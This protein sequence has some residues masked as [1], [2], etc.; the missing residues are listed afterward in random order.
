[1]AVKIPT[2]EDRLVPQGAGPSPN[3]RPAEISD[4]IGRGLQNL[5]NAGM[6]FAATNYHLEQKRQTETAINNMG[7]DL[8][9]AS[10]EWPDRVAKLSKS[11]VNGGMVPQEDGTFKPLTQQ[12]KEEWSTYRQGFLDKI[13]NEKVRMYASSQLD[14]VW[15][16]TYRHSLST[17]ATLNVNNKLDKI[18]QTVTTYASGAATDLGIAE[19]NLKATKELI[20]NSGLDEH[21]RNQTALAAQKSIVEAAVTGALKRDP[22][23][24]RAAL[25]QRFGVTEDQ[26]AAGAN[27]AAT[28]TVNTVW[29]ALINQESGGKQTRPD[30]T[31][32]TSPKGALGIAQIMPGTGPEAAKLAGLPW[33]LNRL[34]TDPDYNEKLGKAYLNK[35]LQTFN[36]DMTKALAAYNM[37]PGEAS[38]GNGVSGLVAKYG[39]QWLEHAPKETQNYVATITQRVG[40][41]NMGTVAVNPKVEIPANL[42]MMVAMLDTDRAPAFLGEA[43]TEIN[44]QQATY[45][46]QVASTENDHVA[47]YMNGQP[48]QKPLSEADYTKAYGPVEGPQR[49][50]Q[51]QQIGVM[52]V[53]MNALKLQT[54]EQMQATVQKYQP[55][56]AKPGYDLANKRYAAVVEAANRVS[57]ARNA[58]PIQY[59]IDSKAAPVATINWNDADKAMA[60]LKNRVGVAATMSGTY[61]TPYALLT[62]AEATNL[63]AGINTMNAVQK[64]AY[65]AT[66]AKAIP[67]QDALHA[68][69]QQIAPD[70]P[71]SAV[72]GK[73][74][75]MDKNNVIREGGIFT[76]ELSYNPQV[77][78]SMIA[79]GE[80]LINPG[81]N[82]KGED[83]K[84]K[85][86]LLPKEQDFDQQFNN[87]IGSTFTGQ[88]RDAYNTAMQAVKAYYAAAAEKDSDYSGVIKPDRLKTAIEAVTGGASNINGTQVRRPWGMM[89]DTFVNK[90]R[91]AFDA[92]M[93]EL[94]RK[95]SNANFFNH[96]LENYGDGYR[97]IDGTGYMR[98]NDGKTIVLDVAGNMAPPARPPANPTQPVG[99][100]SK[101][102]TQT[103]NT[104]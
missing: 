27:P 96:G 95:G 65:F 17:E 3:F 1:M 39:D 42:A 18:G 71:V 99:A 35:Q 74:A 28:G 53:D 32:V 38:K 54:P 97:I 15:A 51:Y 103:P 70:S 100:K 37:G 69:M 30:G 52:G 77:V 83:G 80:E 79:R 26:L 102:N 46:S 81:K 85:M 16:N 93:V 55:D 62:K 87:E 25:L 44:R 92:K 40:K 82:A 23:L 72:V 84:P 4:A 45:K 76:S 6:D 21:T 29:S 5:G 61:G 91:S 43:Q 94:G 20:A 22:T 90:A 101:P 12:L 47:A 36:G 78:A 59:A 10:V 57:T 14:N 49:Y 104:K 34:K 19:T 56:P 73:L 24:T 2:Y 75:T 60:E 86:N 50:A 7:P 66:I 33:D 98:D 63:A 58:D 67:N 9:N 13:P 41:G 88:Q 31:P 8:A 89:P 64:T 11:A 48:V 68:I